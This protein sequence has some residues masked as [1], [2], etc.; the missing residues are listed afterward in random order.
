MEVL[1]LITVLIV[2]A[3][4]FTLV[5]AKYI[6]LPSTIGLMIL[7]LG[8]SIFVVI[9][10]RLFATLRSLAEDIMH[11]YNFS[12]VLLN[13]MLSFLL[14]AGALEINLKK[15]SEEKW[16]ILTLATIGV[17]T[18]TFL[19]GYSMYYFLPLIGVHIS[20]IYCLLFGSLISPTD[21]IA[22]L[23]MIK[24][25]Q[26]SK[27]LESRIAGESLF[28]DGVGVVVFL[29]ILHI[30][31]STTHG[32]FEPTGVLFLFLQEV[33]GGIILGLI[34]GIVGWY[35]LKII[36]NQFTE[37]EVLVT[38]SMV[39]GGSSIAELLH[40][41]GP[42]TMVTMGIMVGREGRSEKLAEVTGDYVYKFWHLLD[43]ALN[44]ILFIL[45]GLQIIII[46]WKPNFFYASG[47]AIV[48]VLLARFIAVGGPL[49]VFRFTGKKL[50]SYTIRI[51]TWSGLR[52]GISVALALSLYDAAEGH[53]RQNV[54][55]L[56]IAM[57]YSVV[58]FSIIV[59]G[60]TVSKLFERM[61][62]VNKNLTKT[63]SAAD[64]NSE[65]QD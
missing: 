36:P 14:F 4:I 33:F 15:L 6:K 18:S 57:T 25:T 59:Q 29:T 13:V 20:F 31:T 60:L 65:K 37:I 52:G 19:I 40:V 26:V 34:I 32:G 47:I 21:P 44:A 42:L 16:I 56:I 1:D 10:E 62:K 27:N 12:D 45:I 11:E 3:A 8:L 22:V 30:A 48:I 50:P 61:D 41:S 58:L 39:M 35:L 53:V 38:L 64:Y 7:A 23:A 55:D 63:N 43:E 2:M 24:K 5:N 51:I 28:N 17:L 46:S 9:G 54:I 49:S